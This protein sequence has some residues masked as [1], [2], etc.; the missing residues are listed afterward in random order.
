MGLIT[1]N[2]L[3]YA[4]RIHGA[5]HLDDQ[6][7]THQ[8]R[9]NDGGTGGGTGCLDSPIIAYVSTHLHQ[10]AYIMHSIAAQQTAVLDGIVDDGSKL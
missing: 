2:P 1:G 9:Q 6:P 5:A 8:Q 10:A 3:S 4:R 7:D